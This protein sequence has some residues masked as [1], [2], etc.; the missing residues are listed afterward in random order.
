MERRFDLAS[1]YLRLGEV[2]QA[3]GDTAGAVAAWKQSVETFHTLTTLPAR[4]M[5]LMGCAHAALAGA[6]GNPGSG[7]AS[8]EATAHVSKALEVLSQ[9]VAGGFRDYA[10]FTTESTL[11]RL[12]DRADFQLLMMDMS[13][14]A[15]PF[16][17]AG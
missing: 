13:F 9:A 5:F 10:A 11:D 2:R 3:E 12:R 7:L 16:A 6:A 8:R 15:R 1:G 4:S 14:P 17:S